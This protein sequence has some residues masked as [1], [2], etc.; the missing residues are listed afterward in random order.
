MGRVS[1]DF[2]TGNTYKRVTVTDSDIIASNHIQTSIQCRDTLVED[3]AGWIYLANVVSVAN[4]SFDVKVAALTPDTH[5]AENNEF[6]N[7]I[8]LLCYSIV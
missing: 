1:V 8:V 5:P 4:G 7:E 3:D 6:P 2:T